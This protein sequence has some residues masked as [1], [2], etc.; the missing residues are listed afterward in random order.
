MG[1]G[2]GLRVCK[3]MKPRNYKPSWSTVDTLRACGRQVADAFRDH[4]RTDS[5]SVIFKSLKLKLQ[6]TPVYLGCPKNW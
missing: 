2:G 4:L 5:A 1:A 3:P 6:Y